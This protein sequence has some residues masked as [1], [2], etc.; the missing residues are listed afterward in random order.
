[1]LATLHRHKTGH[2]AA[3]GGGPAAHP[4]GRRGGPGAR[5]PRH[6]DGRAFTAAVQVVPAAVAE[7]V[8]AAVARSPRLGGSGVRWPISRLPAGI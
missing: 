6:R 7:T 1:V 3:G 5:G 4:T 2:R 8:T